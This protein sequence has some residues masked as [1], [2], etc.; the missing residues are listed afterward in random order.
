MKLKGYAFFNPLAD[1]RAGVFWWIFSSWQ[2][3]RL[4]IAYPVI[5]QDIINYKWFILKHVSK[6]KWNSTNKLSNYHMQMTYNK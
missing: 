5:V 3:K 4:K 6:M 1:E 2:R